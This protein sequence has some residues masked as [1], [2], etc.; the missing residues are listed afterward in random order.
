MQRREFLKVGGRTAVAALA[1]AT[2]RP[3][4]LFARDQTPSSVGLEQRIADVLAAYDAQGNHRTGTPVDNVSAE[5]LAR[6][7]QQSGAEPE[8]EPF[9]LS[10]VDPQSCHVRVANRRVEGV[11]LFDANFTDA[12]GVRGRLGP[13]GSDVEIGLAETEPLGVTEGFRAQAGP[14]AEARQSRHKAVVLLT[15]GSH[16]GLF[17]LNAG[18]FT[19]PI[20]PPTLQVSSVESEW[21]KEQS[22]QRAEATLVAHATRTEAEALNGTVKVAGS[23][24]ALAPL[25]FMAP[26]SGWWQCVS[27][28]GSRLACWLEVI[29]VL[30]AG[31][32]ARDSFFVAMSGH[33][34]GLLGIDADQKRRGD[35]VKRAYAWIFFGSDIG[36]PRQP[37]LIHASDEALEQWIVRALE[38]EGLTVNAKTP[39][40]SAARGEARPVQQGGGRFVTVVCSSEVYHNVADRWPEAVDVATLAR[41]ASA[42][43]NGALDLAQQQS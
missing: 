34:L 32:P 17:L 29:R 5:W 12:E 7:V 6:E 26:R 20:G 41:Y 15:R 4:V 24:P 14:V 25:V 13:L 35:L 22:R 9:G 38:K 30:A 21:L 36:A 39:Y 8:F 40:D 10:R 11:P 19:K 43:A 3:N 31:K 23:N 1:T 28:Q 42:V 27:E 18:S 16:P 33:E 2:G 37:N